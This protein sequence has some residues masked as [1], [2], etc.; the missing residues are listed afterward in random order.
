MNKK[1]NNFEIKEMKLQITGNFKNNKY[2]KQK[3]RKMP[4]DARG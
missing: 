3:E 2:G 1:N 4:G